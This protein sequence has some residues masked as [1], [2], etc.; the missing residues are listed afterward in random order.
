M[1]W[2]TIWEASL[3]YLWTVFPD[4]TN[5]V[6]FFQKPTFSTTPSMGQLRWS[7]TRPSR[8]LVDE[9]RITVWVMNLAACRSICFRSVL[10]EIVSRRRRCW[11][12]TSFLLRADIILWNQYTHIR[13]N[14]THQFYTIQSQHKSPCP[15]WTTF[16]STR[17]TQG[18]STKSNNSNNS[19]DNNNSNSNKAVTLESTFGG[20][21][22]SCTKYPIS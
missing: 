9:S 13:D 2:E 19:S 20:V 8:P 10:D 4:C 15:R 12:R 6:P 14:Y 7:Q 3:V 16:C 1:N 18:F 22:V 11:N 21:T 17:K 5:Q